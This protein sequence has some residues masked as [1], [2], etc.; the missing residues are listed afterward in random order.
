MS[1]CPAVYGAAMDSKQNKKRKLPQP[2]ES[3]DKA[4]RKSEK[5]KAKPVTGDSD[6]RKPAA[7]KVSIIG[8]TRV[9][10]IG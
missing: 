5:A 3:Q 2:K 7:A 9:D 8:H 6:E 10:A 4:T 1:W